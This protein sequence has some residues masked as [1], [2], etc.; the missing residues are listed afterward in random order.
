MSAAP[1]HGKSPPPC[2]VRVNKPLRDCIRAALET[3]FKDLDGH[4][5]GDLY[6]M[7]ICEVEQPLLKSVMEHTRGNQSKAAEILGLNRSTLRKK[8]NLHGLE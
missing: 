7:V 8:L 2:D 3:Y 1:H 4:Q 6:Q 5:A